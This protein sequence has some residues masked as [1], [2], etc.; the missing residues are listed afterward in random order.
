MST[1]FHPVL[2]KSIQFLFCLMVPFTQGP[3]NKSLRRTQIGLPQGFS[4]RLSHKS[5]QAQILHEHK[6]RAVDFLCFLQQKRA[7]AGALRWSQLLPELEMR[8]EGLSLLSFEMPRRGILWRLSNPYLVY[9]KNFPLLL[10]STVFLFPLCMQ[11]IIRNVIHII[12]TFRVLITWKC[13]GPSGSKS[14]QFCSWVNC[15]QNKL[16]YLLNVLLSVNDVKNT[17]ISQG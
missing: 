11:P 14:S 13:P 5:S 8:N 1:S 3:S 7:R 9:E 6:A 2:L 12:L 17:C 4:C 15:E 10:H 16:R